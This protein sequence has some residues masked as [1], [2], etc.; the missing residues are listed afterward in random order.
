M[1]PTAPKQMPSAK[2]LHQL[3][4]EGVE[5]KV[6]GKT[7][8]LSRLTLRD[9]AAFQQHI[10]SERYALHCEHA[11]KMPAPVAAKVALQLLSSPIGDDDLGRRLETLEG[12]EFLVERS[13]QKKQPNVTIAG[14]DLGVD[15][16]QEISSAL[17]ALS[18]PGAGKE[19]PTDE[20]ASA[21]GDKQ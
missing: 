7:Y 13:L 12:I 5:I 15:E 8:I 21:I 2:S 14:L 3:S 20:P 4:D 17:T 16:M 1:N 6:R 18:F 9:M 19:N 10:I 11:A